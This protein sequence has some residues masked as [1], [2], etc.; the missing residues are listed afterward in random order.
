MRLTSRLLLITLTLA[1]LPLHDGCK[2]LDG[3]RVRRPRAGLPGES[4]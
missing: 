2:D 4:L 3:A 1:P